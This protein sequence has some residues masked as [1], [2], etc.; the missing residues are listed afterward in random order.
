MR[1]GAGKGAILS[2]QTVR[3]P[4]RST[5]PR[6]RRGE[7]PRKKQTVKNDLLQAAADAK[8]GIVNS[9]G[10]RKRVEAL[11]DEL[12]AMQGDRPTTGPEL[13][14]VW[15]LAWSSEEETVFLLEKGIWGVGP[16]QNSYQVI[17]VKSNLLQNII[18]FGEKGES[19]FVVDATCK[20]SSPT[21]CQFKFKKAGLLTPKFKLGVPPFGQGWFE[22]VYV[23]RDIRVARDC[24]DNT[25]VVKRTSLSTD[26]FTGRL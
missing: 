14:A 12:V 1:I 25:L 22:N 19:S 21:R 15:E 23:D 11:V 9:E 16:A 17:D 24:R 20:V 26:T 7:N 5:P 6:P 18:V 13:S 2:S 10:R 8:R 4:K 3:S